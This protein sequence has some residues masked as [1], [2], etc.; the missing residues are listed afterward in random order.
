MAKRGRSAVPAIFF[1]TRRCRFTRDARFSSARMLR[2][3][4]GGL[5]GLLPYVLALIPDALALV[6]LG[7][8]DLPDLRGDLTDQLLVDA[9]NHDP[10]GRRHLELDAVRRTERDGV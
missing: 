10:R 4:L 3:S 8:A 5:A 6:R 2:G 7:L 9:S 1:R